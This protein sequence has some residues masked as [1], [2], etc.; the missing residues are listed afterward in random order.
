MVFKEEY[1]K[2]ITPK[3]PVCKNMAS[4]NKKTT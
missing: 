4:S 2:P 3:T 1:V